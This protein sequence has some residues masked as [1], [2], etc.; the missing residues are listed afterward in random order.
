MSNTITIEMEIPVPPKGFVFDG[1]RRV[2]S[3]ERYFSYGKRAWKTWSGTHLSLEDYPVC[4][5]DPNAVIMKEIQEAE[6]IL[7]N[8]TKA[9]NNYVAAYHKR[10]EEIQSEC[11]HT[12]IEFLPPSSSGD[13]FHRCKICGKKHEHLAVLLS[14]AEQPADH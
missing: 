11:P 12:D 6:D 9:Y 7:N 2:A 5:P 1:I 4:K 3:G 8:Q 14:K 10:I 13:R